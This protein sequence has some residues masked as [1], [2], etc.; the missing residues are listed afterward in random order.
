VANGNGRRSADTLRGTAG[1]DVIAG[2]GGND[3]IRGLGP[4]DTPAAGAA[5]TSSRVRA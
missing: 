1:K 4:D 2:L 3:V 5:M